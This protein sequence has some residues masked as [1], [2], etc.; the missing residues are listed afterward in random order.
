MIGRIIKIFSDRYYVET[1]I[2][3]IEA[4]LKTVITQIDGS[5]SVFR[6]RVDESR[7][8]MCFVSLGPRR[9]TVAREGGMWPS[10]ATLSQYTYNDRTA[11]VGGASYADNTIS[12]SSWGLLCLDM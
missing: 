5:A 2:G 12:T 7:T 1:E 11:Y 4:K 3:I 10:T 9:I 6:M 8:A